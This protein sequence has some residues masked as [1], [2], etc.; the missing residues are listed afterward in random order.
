MFFQ[1]N[2]IVISS[3]KLSTHLNT[4]DVELLLSGRRPSR[5]RVGGFNRFG[6]GTFTPL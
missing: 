4:V 1:Y 5:F 3:D 6:V 2:Y